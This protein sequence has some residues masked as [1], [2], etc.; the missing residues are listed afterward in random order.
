MRI[1]N[2]T[3]AAL[4]TT[5][6]KGTRFYD[7][8]LRGFCVRVM[9]DGSKH[10]EVRY[11]TRKSRH[12]LTVGRHGTLTLDQA[13]TRA[14]K[15]LAAVVQGE[16]PAAERERR[17][18]LP[19]FGVWR[20]TYLERIRGR[21]KTATKI[22]EFLV[23][24]ERW[25][26][27]GLD[28]ITTAD[29]EAL[30]QKIGEKH[31][32]MANRFLQSL[33]PLFVAAVRD[34]L[35]LT[36]PAAGIRHFRENPPRARV[37]TNDEM[38]ALLDAVAEEQDPHARAAFALLVETGARLSEVL[39]AKWEDVDL[40]AALWRLPSPK[41]G[42]PQMIPLARSTVAHLRR[43][44]HVG[45][46]IV[47]GRQRKEDGTNEKKE[48]PRFD[49]KRPWAS[50]LARAKEADARARDERGEKA[51]AGFLAD[52]HVHDVRRTFGLSVARSAGL[53]VAS[54][55]LR[56][57]SVAITE[58]IYAPL[59]LEEL[60]RATEKHSVAIPFRKRSR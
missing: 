39:R 56:H 17:R 57:G 44:P 23:S 11:G 27:R 26:S 12:R 22:K 51:D 36:N 48:A 6:P 4:T 32:T 38:R 34:G 8:D 37:L 46:F 3:L 45:P 33:S 47:A 53:H 25:D 2:R 13:R 29:V 19:T 7:V 9:A 59:G 54:K 28:T 30:F 18:N 15:I 16:D 43:L 10:F 35:I 40:D 31:P 49:L 58:R 41:S 50:V 14:K 55:L 60:R 52:V 21:L 1:T 42:H 24:T 5:S 20:A